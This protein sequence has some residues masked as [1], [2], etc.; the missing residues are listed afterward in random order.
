MAIF[1][2]LTDKCRQSYQLLDCANKA[3]EDA[4]KTRRNARRL[5]EEIMNDPEYVSLGTEEEKSEILNRYVLSQS[6]PEEII[7]LD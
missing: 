6:R 2:E 5:F 4:D 1:N 7:S 3:Y